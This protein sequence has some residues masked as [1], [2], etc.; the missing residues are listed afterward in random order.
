MRRGGDLDR[1]V[2]A[3]GIPLLEESFT[4][5]AQ[6]YVSLYQ[7]AARVARVF[8]RHRFQVW[9]SFHYSD[10]YTEPII[11]RL[12]GAKAWM[13]TK[14]NM[15][16]HRRAWY[17]RSLLA[18]TVAAQNTAMLRRFFHGP[19]FRRKSLLVAPSVDTS[20]YSPGT[21][22]RLGLRTQMGLGPETI[23]V[24]C[25]ANLLPVKGHTTLIGAVAR[26]PNIH[27]WLAG[28][29]MDE[30]HAAR[31]ARLCEE[32]G[33]ANRVHFLGAIRDVPAL[34]AEVDLF[35]LT[36]TGKIGE[37]CPVALLE[38]MSCQVACVAT[39]VSGSQ[40]VIEDGMSGV[41]VP[42]DDESA[43]AEVLKRLAESP[44]LRNRLAQGARHRI[45]DAYLLDREVRQYEQIY[46]RLAGH[47]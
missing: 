45:L 10:D 13:Y 14:K 44:E 18:S 35:A 24:G 7:R 12:A 9:H 46:S 27:L 34:L 26:T 5:L 30:A 40:D 29:P 19:L 3:Q 31:L 39:D 41:L 37:G 8:R 1:E 33:V 47:G 28:K 11:A 15:N 23:V 36:S 25:V 6:P 21:P 20:L 16:W 42:P 43:L 17:M 2:E 4:V 32:L 22:P 38:A